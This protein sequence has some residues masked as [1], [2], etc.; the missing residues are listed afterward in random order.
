MGNYEET[1]GLKTEDGRQK[2][3]DGRQ[4]SEERIAY[5]I[6]TLVFGLLTSNYYD[7][8]AT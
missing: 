5:P 6:F 4:K 3:E 8:T 7:F 2:M 1:K